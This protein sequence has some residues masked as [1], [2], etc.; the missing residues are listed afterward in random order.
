MTVALITPHSGTTL[1]L[2]IGSILRT[3]R[4]DLYSVVGECHNPTTKATMV[5]YRSIED[6]TGA[7]L[8]TGSEDIRPI[9]SA[10]PALF[11][12]VL[13]PDDSALKSFWK[14]WFPEAPRVLE[15]VLAQYSAPWRYFHTERFLRRL[16]VL[17][18]NLNLPL[19]KEDGLALALFRV[20]AVPGAS[21]QVQLE[22]SVMVGKSLMAESRDLGIAWGLVIRHWDPKHKSVIR[23]LLLSHLAADPLE[24]CVTEELNWLENRTVYRGADGRKD[25]DTQRLKELI[26]LIGNGAIYSSLGDSFEK[27]ARVNIEGLRQAWRQ[28]YAQA[29]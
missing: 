17:A 8:V 5:L 10:E 13:A 24:F 26:A 28:K 3:P 12:M 7:L 11:N 25:Y 27:R 19:T 14:Q 1:E 16:F 23:D 4:G 21:E 15:A 9:G 18:K 29:K 6:P 22:Q 20:A 2:P